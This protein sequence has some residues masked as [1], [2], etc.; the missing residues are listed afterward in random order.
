[1]EITCYLKQAPVL[2]KELED[3]FNEFDEDDFDLYITRADY[4]GNSFLIDFALDVEDINERG[5]ISQ[6]WTI[7]ATEHRKNHISLDFAPFI[8]I[9][10]DHPLL[11]EF[12]DTQ[13]QLYFAGQCKNPEK[14][15]YDLYATHKSMFGRHQC[16]NIYLG[17]ETPCFKSFQYSSGLLAQG[18]KKLMERYA[19]CLRQN[20][21][22]FTIIGEQPP[23]YWDGKQFIL[24]DADLKVLFLGSTYVIAKYFSFRQQDENSR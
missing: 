3:I 16:F 7:E 13:C 21:L 11:W 22:D 19:D 4:S 10:I 15:F 18:S 17:E 14:L 1:L 20:G 9:K 12:T 2:P 6:K 23:R 24:G 5:G 8:E